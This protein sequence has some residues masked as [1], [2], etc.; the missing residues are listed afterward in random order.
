MT[1]IN[2]RDETGRNSQLA[3][4][5]SVFLT[6]AAPYVEQI[7]GLALPHTVTVRLLTVPDLAK[8]FS[9]FIRRQVERDTTDAELTARERKKVAAL[10]IDAGRAARTLWAVDASV[11]VA[12]TVGWPSTLV[13][14]KALAH[15]GLLSD[16]DG[17]CELL[18]RVLTEQAQVEACRGVLVPG[19]A[20]PPVREDQSPVVQLSTG[21]ACWAGRRTTPLVLGKP[22]SD[23]QRRPSWTYR[24]QAA[25][26]FLRERGQR[27]RRLLRSTAFVEQAMD[28]IGSEGFNRLWTMHELVPTLDELRHPDQWLR[29]QP[30]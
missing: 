28:S 29:R 23:R 8:D 9:A 10:P 11:L 6:K 15:Q 2:V 12:N 19:G 1:T 18:V 4:D 5:M 25:L 13:V 21:H 24:R 7:T 20:W 22:V 3:E 26:V 27:G 14:P 16:P 30:A 17:L